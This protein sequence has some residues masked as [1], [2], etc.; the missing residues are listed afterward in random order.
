M[1]GLTLIKGMERNGLKYE[2]GTIMDPRDG[3][4]YRALMELSP[5]GKKL[6]VRGYL[7]IA[8]FGRTQ[9][10]NRL[11]DNAM[12][13][14][15]RARPGATVPAPKQN[16]SA[17]QA[18]APKQLAA[19]RSSAQIDDAG[20]AGFGRKCQELAVGAPGQRRDRRVA[21]LLRQDFGAI[22]DAHEQHEPVRIAD[23]DDR[24]PRDGRRRPRPAP[25]SAPACCGVLP[26]G[27]SLPWNGHR[28]SCVEPEVASHLPSAVQSSER[29]RAP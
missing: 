3:S 1:L 17:K 4:V 20:L 22:L 10:W 11:P 24:L 21:G 27:P 18:P 6:E 9:T 13:A 2:D 25:P 12:D 28:M 5:D 8:L 14:R 7:G 23:R 16:P 26:I 19:P 29:T 15:S